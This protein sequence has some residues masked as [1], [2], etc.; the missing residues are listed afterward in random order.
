MDRLFAKVAYIAQVGIAVIAE[1]ALPQPTPDAGGG[2]AD[3]SR[4]LVRVSGR[5]VGHITI[6]GSEL[7]IRLQRTLLAEAAQVFLIDLTTFGTIS[8]L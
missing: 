5:V 8:N 6:D 2:N 7:L 3:M 4:Y 1:L